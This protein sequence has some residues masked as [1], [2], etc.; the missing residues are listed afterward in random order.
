M[1][2]IFILGRLPKKKKGMEV[3]EFLKVVLLFLSSRGDF[4]LPKM[5]ETV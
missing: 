5:I 4:F 2:D 3:S 1:E